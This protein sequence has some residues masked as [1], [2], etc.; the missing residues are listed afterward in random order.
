LIAAS[1][2]RFSRATPSDLSGGV[3]A[4]SGREFLEAKLVLIAFSDVCLAM[5]ERAHRGRN[6]MLTRL[7]IVSFMMA[8][9]AGYSELVAEIRLSPDIPYRSDS[10]ADRRTRLDVY[11]TAPG[12]D[13]PVVLWIHGGAWRIGSKGF[14]GQKP[15]AFTGR[16]CVL[17]SME[18]RLVPQVDYRG[19]ADDVAQ[20]LRWIHDHIAD[21]GGSAEKVFVMGH[22]SGA[23]LAA[24]VAL[25]PKYLQRVELTPSALAGVILIDGAGYDLP[26]Q[27]ALGGRG[28]ARFYHSIFGDDPAVLADASPATHVA[29]DRPAPPFFI[30]YCEQREAA[31]RDGIALAEKLRS[32]GGTPV[33]LPAKGKTHLT[34]N[35]DLGDADDP[36]TRHLWTFLRETLERK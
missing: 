15:A 32:A 27:I 4:F 18:Y 19:Q 30:T 1:A 12:Q 13:R 36:V 14:L 6:A 29:K 34:I 3:A 22:S 35:R 25:E 23:H 5:V 2:N 26:R 11:W 16:N 24:L 31:A 21:F 7:G 33:V 20:A 17:V 8:W 9:L 28:V 10:Q